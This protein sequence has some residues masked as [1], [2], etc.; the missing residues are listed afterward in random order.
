MKHIFQAR[1]GIEWIKFPERK[2]IKQRFQE[3]RFI[4][5]DFQA[6]K[7]VTGK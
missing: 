7:D 3:R 4:K 6:S 5:E 1:K 2:S